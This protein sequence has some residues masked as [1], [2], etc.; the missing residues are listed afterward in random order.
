MEFAQTQSPVN[1]K[2]YYE[3]GQVF[4]CFHGKAGICIVDQREKNLKLEILKGDIAASNVDVI[5]NAANTALV[6]GAGVAG[7]IRRRGGAA[8]QAECD[9]HGPISEGEIAVTSAGNLS[10]RYLFHAATMRPGAFS[11]VA[12]IATAVDGIFTKAQELQVL[13]L[14]MPAIGCGIG[15]IEFE[16]GIRIILG[17]IHKHW[18]KKVQY[19]QTLQLVLFQSREF[20]ITQRIATELKLP[21]T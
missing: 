13:T 20:M 9:A 21:L 8:I 2:I 7:A 16:V 6:L 11:S 4:S 17:G 1:Y 10:A 5:V 15:G 12:I 19:P 14:A 18:K 3:A